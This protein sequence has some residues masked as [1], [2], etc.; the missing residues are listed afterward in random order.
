[1]KE[2]L[3]PESHRYFALAQRQMQEAGSAWV[4]QVIAANIEGAAVAFHYLMSRLP[5]ADEYMKRV[6]AHERSI[7]TDE[8]HH[9]PEMME[10]LAKTAQSSGEVE[11][12]KEKLIELRVQELRQRNEQFLHPLIL[13][14]FAEVERDFLQ[15]RV[16]P[17]ALFSVGMSA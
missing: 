5:A 15:K 12:A 6:T 8:L 1:M 2:S 7:A 4:R 9:G 13:A 14:E 16:E 10:Q 3:W 11:E 17:I